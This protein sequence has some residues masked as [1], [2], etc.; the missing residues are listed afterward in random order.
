MATPLAEQPPDGVTVLQDGAATT[1]I[2]QPVRPTGDLRTIAL[3][4]AVAF[5]FGVSMCL[6]LVFGGAKLDPYEFITLVVAMAALGGVGLVALLL[7]VYLRLRKSVFVLYADSLTYVQTTFFWTSRREW[8]RTMI[9]DCRPAPTGTVLKNRWHGTHTI[10]YQL[11]IRLRSGGTVRLLTGHDLDHLEWIAAYLRKHLQIEPGGG[12]GHPP[13][14]S[15]QSVTDPGPCCPHA[16]SASTGKGG[17]P[18]G[19]LKSASQINI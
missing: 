11:R 10:L 7:L 6:W 17:V 5:L 12:E 16:T 8:P 3:P 1:C 19:P 9:L 18:L 15:P 13:P 4:V 2:V 14:T